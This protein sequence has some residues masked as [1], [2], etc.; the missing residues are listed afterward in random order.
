MSRWRGRTSWLALL[1]VVFYGLTPLLVPL[2][3]RASAPLACAASPVR[4]CCC[5]A[6]IQAKGQCC[7]SKSS[8]GE[9]CKLKRI[10]CDGGT[11]PDG[12]PWS[13]IHPLE[14]PAGAAQLAA[15]VV[16][17]P[18]FTVYTPS[19]LPVCGNIPTPPPQSRVS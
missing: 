10:P 18:S 13:A 8:A 7:C 6:D 11:A 2:A 12:T 4:N 14:L 9:S 1:A 17:R 16:A 3:G 19:V 15:S 5:S